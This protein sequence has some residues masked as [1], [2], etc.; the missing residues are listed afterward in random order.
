M[1]PF[2]FIFACIGLLAGSTPAST[3]VFTPVFSKEGFHEI[4][5]GQEDDDDDN[6]GLHIKW[7]CPIF[8]LCF[9]FSSAFPAVL[10]DKFFLQFVFLTSD[11]YPSGSKSH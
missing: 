11:F 10:R 7:F 4:G 9:F 8:Y 1:L 2:V 3:A 6:N 5:R